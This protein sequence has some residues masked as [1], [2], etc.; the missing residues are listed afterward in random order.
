MPASLRHTILLLLFGAICA[1]AA[2][3][4]PT[5]NGNNITLTLACEPF[6]GLPAF[7]LRVCTACEDDVVCAPIAR[8]LRFRYSAT[9]QP[10]TL[11]S[12][13]ACTARALG[14]A[15]AIPQHCAIEAARDLSGGRR[16]LPEVDAVWRALMER[17]VEGAVIGQPW[18]GAAG[19][20]GPGSGAAA[21]VRALVY[22]AHGPAGRSSLLPS[23]L[24]AELSRGDGRD[25][26]S[27]RML[28]VLGAVAVVMLYVAWVRRE[29][30]DKLGG[31]ALR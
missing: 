19:A 18:C 4:P 10:C 2:T 26:L 22:A 30:M 31:V 6:G 23:V 13:A 24:E 16:L 3:S 29:I 8:A 21:I 9:N 7:V 1:H 5:N 11:G 28:V 12:P 27:L 15:M 20:A 14:A 25:A 17:A